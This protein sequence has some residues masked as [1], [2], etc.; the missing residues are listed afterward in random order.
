MIGH[1][2]RPRRGAEG[3]GESFDGDNTIV[4]QASRVDLLTLTRREREVW[5]AAYLSG[6]CCGHE[7]GAKWADEQAASVHREAVRIVHLMAGL[8]EVDP[9]ECRRAALRRERR[10]AS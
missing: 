1:E 4:S 8:P 5:D 7:A 6:Y 10:W 9:E 3:V 2:Q